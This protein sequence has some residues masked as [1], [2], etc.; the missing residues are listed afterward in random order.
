V[1]D[2]S[3]AEDVS[4]DTIY[5]KG[6]YVAYMLR[7]IIGEP[8]YFD[9]LA[10]FLERFRYQQAS[11]AD[12]Q[13]TLEEVTGRDLE[14]YF[15]DWIRSDRLADLA[16][17]KVG[18]GELEV[19]NAG[20][21]RI[22]GDIA[23]WKFFAQRDEP[24]VI[25]VQVGQRLPL[26]PEVDYM[27]LDPLLEWADVE[28]EN[29][30]FP[31]RADPIAVAVSPSGRILATIGA[32]FA[33]VR[34]SV[35]EVSSGEGGANIWDF[36]RGLSRYPR[37]GGNG[38]L[39]VVAE[40]KPTPLSSI[41]TLAP[42]GARRIFGDGTSPELM[43]DGSIVAAADDRL[44]QWSADG[45]KKTLLRRKGFKIAQPNL[46]RDGSRIAYVSRRGNDFEIRVRE[47]Q[48][49]TDNTVLLWD[50]DAILCTWAADDSRLFVGLGVGWDW[51]IWSVPL[52][53]VQ[54]TQI[55]AA[56]AVS[57]ADM[58]LSPDG[59]QL[60]FA[61]V[62]ALDYPLN[63]HRVYVQP[64][65]GGTVQMFDIPDATVDAL[66]WENPTSLIVVSRLWREDNPWI[67]PATRKMQRVNLGDSSIN[68]L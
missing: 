10:Q 14:P 59:E 47:L 25:S 29:N 43:P 67:L 48:S 13:K 3:V 18:D 2:N 61:A 32:P 63:R 51:Q 26:D 44:V 4:R 42:D 55:L 9:A 45:K 53:P 68:D 60:A 58:A 6:A 17:E 15:D 35:R 65:G 5:R 64:V 37:F 30:R 7:H 54:P 28:R 40:A 46:S 38:E 31:R 34:A 49:G 36:T 11:D 1:F 56:D 52:D 66:T 41:A 16:I 39:A 27:I 33:W 57:I 19:T 23:L 20:I 50:G 24:E 12:M 21:A 62:P 8:Q 22:A